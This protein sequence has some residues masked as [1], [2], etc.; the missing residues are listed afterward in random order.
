[1]NDY[2]PSTYTKMQIG[3]VFVM[4]DVRL[5]CVYMLDASYVLLSSH[6]AAWKPIQNPSWKEIWIG[7]FFLVSGGNAICDGL[8]E[9]RLREKRPDNQNEHVSIRRKSLQSNA[10]IVINVG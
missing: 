7:S 4:N 2:H 5:N 10:R 8:F 1:M 6:D 3:T 9:V